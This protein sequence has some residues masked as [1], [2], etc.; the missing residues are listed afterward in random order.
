[1]PTAE[2]IIRILQKVPL[3]SGL[4]R[5][6][7]RRLAARVGELTYPPRSTV[8][9]QGEPGL[10]Y[11]IILQGAVR[12]T[13][14]DP[15]GRVEEVRRLGPG[16][17]FGETSLL[18]GDVRDATIET[19]E[20]TVFLYIDKE[21]FDRLLAA[22][23]SME[24]ALR[25]REDVAE[26]RRYPRFSWLEAGELPVKVLRK[27][28]FALIDRLILSLGILV[29]LLLLGVGLLIAG[30]GTL[31]SLIA[32]LLLLVGTIVPLGSVLYF[33]LDWRNDIYILTN[34]RVV[35]RERV[36]AFLIQENFSA[37]PL[38][39]IQ[40]V[41]VIQVG[42]PGRIWKFGDL[43][44]ETAGAAGQ[45]VFRSIPDPWSVQQAIL[46]QQARV[47]SMARI[48]ERE[49]I[50]KAVRRHFL[51][52][53]EEEAQKPP[54][55]PE[56]RPGVLMFLRSFF[57]PSWTREGVTV[58]WRRH[59]VTLL[60][61]VWI[62]LLIMV[63][64]TVGVVLLAR[65]AHQVPPGLVMLYG[66][67]MFFSLPWFLWQFEDWQNDF[68][69]VTATR[70]IQVDRMPL[71]L[72][73]QRREASLEQVTNVRFEQGILG[74]ILRYGDVFVETAAPAGTFHFQKVSRPQ[75][76]QREIFA[77]IDAARRRRQQEEARQRQMEMLDWLSAYDELRR[78]REGETP[79][80]EKT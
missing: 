25:M 68:F 27:H 13:R 14:V 61:A 40:N 12:A 36:G 20:N 62:P 39:A 8:C 30:R 24:R 48:Q 43:I 74:K 35:H 60:G 50:R 78:S 21:D 52:E 16:E 32:G 59:W 56:K 69:Q 31:A 18:L 75:E 29:L 51:F 26:R 76:V 46:E 63:L 5:P 55:E 41:Q 22:D 70:I 73:E 67:V 6:Q 15:E 45:V 44:V 9:L 72:R 65:F 79:S 19:L 58:T 57:P 28:I 66:L 54:A 33:Y 3:F 2:E 64:S 49:A 42:L 23:P 10:R 47:R 38:Q 1:M 34:R 37:A 4:S 11:Y 17:A 71:F 7:L 53:E 80:G 77:H